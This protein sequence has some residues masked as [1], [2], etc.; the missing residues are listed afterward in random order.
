MVKQRHEQC[1]EDVLKTED[2]WHARIAH[3][4]ED[5]LH[6]ATASLVAKTKPVGKQPE[7]IGIENLQVSGMLKNRKLARTI[8]DVGMYEFR[9]QLT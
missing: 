9:R 4:C 2:E 3:I 7:V 8:A 5:A 6:K 1:V